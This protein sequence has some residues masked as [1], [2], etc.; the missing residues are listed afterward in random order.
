M[1]KG[2]GIEFP[3]FGAN[4]PDA[5]CCDG[6]LWDMDSW[7]ESLGGFTIGGD[8]PC[9]VC[10]TEEWL[11]FVVDED[12]EFKTKEDGEFKT[13]EEALAYVEQLKKMYLDY[14]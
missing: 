7:D 13:K 4:Y 10:N 5:R 8:E 2:C 12:G 6:Y 3:H 1:S 9:P 11:E 14:E